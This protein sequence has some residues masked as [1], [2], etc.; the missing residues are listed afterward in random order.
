M[1]SSM[2][3][4]FHRPTTNRTEPLTRNNA[5]PNNAVRLTLVVNG[6]VQD[7]EA[8]S[9]TTLLEVLRDQLGL[10]GTKAGCGNGFCGACTV[11]R[12]GRRVNACLALALGCAESEITTIEDLAGGDALHPLQK[13]FLDYDA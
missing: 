4:P 9:L 2:R 12:N 1:T 3:P 5:P 10:T 7:V 6:A 13:A 11:L 8:D